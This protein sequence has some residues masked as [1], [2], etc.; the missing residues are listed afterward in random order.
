MNDCSPRDIRHSDGI[1]IGVNM[2]WL[3]C[4]MGSPIASFMNSRAQKNLNG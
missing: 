2:W 3:A 4:R 1:L